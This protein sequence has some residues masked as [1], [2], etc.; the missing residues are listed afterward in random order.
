MK[1]LSFG[2]GSTIV[3]ATC[4]FGLFF[5]QSALGSNVRGYISEREVDVRPTPVPFARDPS[6]LVLLQ[7]GVLVLPHLVHV[8][9]M[10]LRIDNIYTPFE[11]ST[12]VWLRPSLS[13]HLRQSRQ[14][15]R[16]RS[17]WASGVRG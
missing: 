2:D 12:S 3:P 6:R 7:V 17:C 5:I 4:I 16:G 11:V 1:G 9:Q 15:I 14:R 10:L 8:L 13:A